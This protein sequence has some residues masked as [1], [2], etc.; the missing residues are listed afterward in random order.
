M[1]PTNT[2]RFQEKRNALA[3]AMAPEEQQAG[4]FHQMREGYFKMLLSKFS[5]LSEGALWKK[6][7]RFACRDYL[8]RVEEMKTVYRA[9]NDKDLRGFQA[10][11]LYYLVRADFNPHNALLLKEEEEKATRMPLQLTE[12]V[13]ANG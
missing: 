6:A 7:H 4:G 3:K 11:N 5:L 13:P 2:E 8:T 1:A 9:V 10:P 12:E